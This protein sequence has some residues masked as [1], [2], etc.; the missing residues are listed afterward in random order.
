MNAKRIEPP[1]FVAKRIEPGF[2]AKRIEPGF[3]AKKNVNQSAP[4][5]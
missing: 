5:P 2:V 4:Q 1:G 3:V